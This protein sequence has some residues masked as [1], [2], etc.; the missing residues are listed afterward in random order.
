MNKNISIECLKFDV[1]GPTI[2]QATQTNYHTTVMCGNQFVCTTWCVIGPTTSKLST[3]CLSVKGN[4]PVIMFYYR[5]KNQG[6]F[7]FKFSCFL[8]YSVPTTTN[9]DMRQYKKAVCC[10]TRKKTQFSM[11]LQWHISI[12]LVC[13]LFFIKCVGMQDEYVDLQ[14][15]CVYMQHNYVDNQENSINYVLLA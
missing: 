15:S 1:V 14:E 9:K 8:M 7:L 4:C 2:H 13:K 3:K 6:F 5:T 10:I 12:P 11:H